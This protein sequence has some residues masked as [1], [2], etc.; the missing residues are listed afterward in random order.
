MGLD[1]LKEEL[2][3]KAQA[4][5]H[6]ILATA[7]DEAAKIVEKAKLK[8]KEHERAEIAVVRNIIDSIE[9][10]EITTTELEI[11]KQ[12]LRIKKES[13]DAVFADALKTL[14]KDKKSSKY[15]NKLLSKAKKS[16][17]VATVYGNSKDKSE[18]S[19]VEF[20]SA[21][22]TGGLIAESKDGSIIIDYSYDTVMED[23]KGQV[24]TN[25]ARILFENG[26]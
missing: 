18:F 6:K 7:K 17:D 12:M 4:E 25:V 3:G 21:D 5:R 16:M 9:R 11:K 22:I 2:K 13:I 10:K 24:L 15:L 20:K 26:K 19:E 8:A 14:A 1:E 23:L